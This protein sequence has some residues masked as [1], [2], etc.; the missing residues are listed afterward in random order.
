MF[1]DRDSLTVLEGKL[2]KAKNKTKKDRARRAAIMADVA[3][4]RG[5][6]RLREILAGRRPR[7]SG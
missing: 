6:V 3:E 5:E 1:I 4:K 7:P 2:N